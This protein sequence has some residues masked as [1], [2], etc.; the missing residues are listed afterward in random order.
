MSKLS[1]VNRY[2]RRPGEASL[3][4]VPSAVREK[5]VPR[6]GERRDMSHLASRHEGERGR[7]RQPEDVLQPVA[8]S[9]LEDREGRTARVDSGVLIPCRA[10]PIG[11][12]RRGKRAADGPCE[13]APAPGRQKPTFDAARKLVDHLFG[14]QALVLELDRA[15][16]SQTSASSVQRCCAP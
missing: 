11:R 5:L 1:R 7:R 2:L 15:L 10:Q 3:L 6:C 13:E 12:E 4:H 14:R 9:I 8:A 16:L